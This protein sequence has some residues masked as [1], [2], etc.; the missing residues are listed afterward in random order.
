MLNLNTK[1][2][3]SFF[4]FVFAFWRCYVNV[5]FISSWQWRKFKHGSLLRMWNVWSVYVL[6]KV[7]SVVGLWRH[8][9]CNWNKSL[10]SLKERP[11]KYIFEQAI[12]QI[13]LI[14]KVS[15]STIPTTTSKKSGYEY[16]LLHKSINL[17]KKI[18]ETPT[19]RSLSTIWGPSVLE[20]QEG[21]EQESL[22]SQ[23]W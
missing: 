21:A 2:I 8:Q 22:F 15:T 10:P 4:F 5:K 7:S 9:Y 6:W 1:L 3:S 12:N 19:F 17:R 16:L 11:Y 20:V 13:S 23:S 18:D 14:M